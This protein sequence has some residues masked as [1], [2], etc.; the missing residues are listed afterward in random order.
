MPILKVYGY[1]W[2]T[3][4]HKFFQN[5]FNHEILM[6]ELSDKEVHNFFLSRQSLSIL[7]T[8]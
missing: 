2:N 6:I 1:F 7:L 4:Q 8:F 5:V 3:N